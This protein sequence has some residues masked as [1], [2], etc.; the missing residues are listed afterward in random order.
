MGFKARDVLLVGGERRGTSQILFLMMMSLSAAVSRSDARRRSCRRHDI[1]ATVTKLRPGVAFGASARLE[2]AR[3]E[4]AVGE[5]EPAPFACVQ[6][7]GAQF[8]PPSVLGSASASATHC[9]EKLRLSR[10]KLAATR[11]R[12]LG[13]G[14]LEA[15]A[16]PPRISFS[17][18]CSCCPSWVVAPFCCWSFFSFFTSVRCWPSFFRA[19]G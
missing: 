5:K 11:T 12:A 15:R 8:C 10:T 16:S 18:R 4:V 2:S 6:A 9:D 14:V 19:G 7:I 17:V 1:D 3:P 13:S